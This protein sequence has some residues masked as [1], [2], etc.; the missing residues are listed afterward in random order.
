M[1]S[2]VSPRKSTRQ[3]QEWSIPGVGAEFV[4]SNLRLSKRIPDAEIL[5]REV[6]A[7]V[8]ER[9]AKAIRVKW[10]STTQDARRKLARLYPRVPS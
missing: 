7:H 4:W 3:V 10:R 5:Q 1:L 9:N 6:D 8:C 2:L